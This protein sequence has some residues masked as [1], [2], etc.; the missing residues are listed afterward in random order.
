MR[1][2]D[3]QILDVI[4]L[5]QSLTGDAAAAALL[6][7]V[8]VHGHALDVARVGQRVAAVL[9]LDQIL[10]VDLVLDVLNL[11][12]AVVAV[13]VADGGQFVF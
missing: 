6:R 3:E 1:G 9:L 11:R 2:G 13:L 4:F 5:L 8:G 12:A 7:A 10:D